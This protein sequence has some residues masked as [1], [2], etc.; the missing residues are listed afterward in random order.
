M[1]KLDINLIVFKLY[2][3]WKYSLKSYKNLIYLI[4]NKL[5]KKFL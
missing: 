3:E 5:K 1:I 2:L 4:K